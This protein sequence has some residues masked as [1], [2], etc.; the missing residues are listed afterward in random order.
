V[1]WSVQAHPFRI[2]GSACD[3]RG[4]EGEG[5]D[6]HLDARE[7]MSED[8]GLGRAFKISDAPCPSPPGASAQN[9][10]PLAFL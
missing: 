10:V 2:I 1:F 8:L 6:L 9:L 7:G 4:G 5:T 3:G